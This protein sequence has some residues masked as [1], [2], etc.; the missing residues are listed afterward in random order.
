MEKESLSTAL[1]R[2]A[3]GLRVEELPEEAVHHVRRAL[4]DFLGVTLG[5]TPTELVRS[6]HRYVQAMEPRGKSSVIGTDLRVSLAGAALA[7]GAA[8]SVLELDDGHA[9][10]TIHPG[11]T[12]IPAILAVAEHKN[13]TVGEVLLAI[14]IAYETAS[15]LG[16]AVSNGSAGKGFHCTTIVGVIA[17]TLGVSKI[18]GNDVTAAT[19]AIGLAGSNAGGFFDYH[20]GWLNAWCIN[21]GRAGREGLLCATLPSSGISGPADILDGPNGYGAAFASSTEHM[22]D[23]LAGLG[24]EWLM[25]ETAVKAYP[26]CRRLH[27][28]IDAILTLRNANGIAAS[29]VDRIVV[30]TS[31]ESARLDRKTFDDTSAAQMSIPYGAAAA[32]VFGKPRIEHFSEDARKHPQLLN[33][34]QRVDVRTT[35]DP[36]IGDPTRFAAL[37]SVSADGQTFRQL[38]TATKGDPENPV[39][40]HELEEKFLGLATPVIGE[41]KARTTAATIWAMHDV[42]GSEGLERLMLECCP[43]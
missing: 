4:L 20:S 33:L 34:A 25:L 30:E 19:H 38:V 40:D 21:T 32:F 18:I 12:T 22:S 43:A 10:A 6:V 29:A 36:R 14:A 8:A 27:P 16:I 31:A 15:R 17:A 24:H 39:M 9:R 13:A 3:V 11:A 28:V 35:D 37:V 7:N 23:V 5:G 1:A 42:R 41:E 2:W 26:C